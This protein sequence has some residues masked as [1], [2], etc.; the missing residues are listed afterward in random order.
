VGDFSG[1][2]ASDPVAR[3]LSSRSLPPREVMPCEAKE[4]RRCLSPYLE[5]EGTDEEEAL[6]LLETIRLD[7]L[8]YGSC[9]TVRF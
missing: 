6:P 8:E 3:A 5:P 4:D 1:E 2:A 7:C 9:S